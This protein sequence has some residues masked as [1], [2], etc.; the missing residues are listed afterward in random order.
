[1]YKE[2]HIHIILDGNCD[3]YSSSGYRL[4]FLGGYNDTS[5]DALNEEMCYKYKLHE[6]RHKKG[7]KKRE[8]IDNDTITISMRICNNNDDENVHGV[9]SD[10]LTKVNIFNNNNEKDHYYVD[11]TH[12][13]YVSYPNEDRDP[14]I[15]LCFSPRDDDISSLNDAKIVTQTEYCIKHNNDNQLCSKRGIFMTDICGLDSISRKEYHSP[16]S[17]I[18]Y[19]PIPGQLYKLGDVC[20][21]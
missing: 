5:I 20:H 17:E 2:A 18:D 10:Y 12:F 7:L 21:R 16:A 4:Q 6:Y 19:I 14:V 15:E 1:M 3:L 8:R 13:Y 11:N 9:V